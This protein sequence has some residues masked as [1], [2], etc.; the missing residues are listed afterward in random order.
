MSD[1]AVA[2]SDNVPYNLSSTAKSELQYKI[3][4]HFRE[5]TSSPNAVSAQHSPARVSPH[6]RAY[7]PSPKPQVYSPS[8]QNRVY[9]PR[10]VEMSVNSIKDDVSVIQT[11]SEQVVYENGNHDEIDDVRK[12][13]TETALDYSETGT[14]R[15]Y[16]KEGESEIILSEQEMRHQNG[17]SEANMA[18]M[19][20]THQENLDQH[21]NGIAGPGED[22]MGMQQQGVVKA[23]DMS[24]VLNYSTEGNVYTQLGGPADSARPQQLVTIDPSYLNAPVSEQTVDKETGSSVLS[25]VLRSGYTVQ[26]MTHLSANSQVTSIGSFDNAGHLLPQAD[27]EAF[28]TDMERPM[29]TSVS[30]AGMYTAGTGQFT[31]LTNPPGLAL[32]QTYVPGTEG[33]RLVTLQPPSYSD[34]HTDYALTQLYSRPA[35]VQT[36]YLTND[37]SSSSSPTPQA[38]TSWGVAQ[39]SMYVATTS[40]QSLGNQGLKYSYS[41]DNTVT[42]DLTLQDSQLNN[43]YSRTSGLI[44]SNNSYTT[45]LTQDV[46]QASWYQNVPSPYSDVRPTGEFKVLCYYPIIV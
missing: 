34:T 18:A 43:Q 40:G 31:T 23:E 12:S 28:F 39:D 30:L 37:G 46:N 33:S 7:T 24:E 41:T 11:G 21:M 25:A 17:M 27:V 5:E 26:N 10:Q 20:L 44:G 42:R 13:V 4:Q 3:E 36:Q 38:N 32:A 16:D 45:Y 14:E 19:T 9:S 29:A 1:T 35:A 22:E 2:Q 15:D 8:S 6:P